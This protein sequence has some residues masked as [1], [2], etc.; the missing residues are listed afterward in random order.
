MIRI[1]EEV[2]DVRPGDIVEVIFLSQTGN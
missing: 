1:P 2:T